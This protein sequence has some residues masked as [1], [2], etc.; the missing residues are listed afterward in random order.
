MKASQFNRFLSLSNS[1]RWNYDMV[2]TAEV[3]LGFPGYLPDDVY[4][5]C[6]RCFAEDALD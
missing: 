6:R 5:F 3:D 4:E 1:R 2:N